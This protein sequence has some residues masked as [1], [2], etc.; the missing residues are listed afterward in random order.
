MHDMISPAVGRLLLA[1]AVGLCAGCGSHPPARF[2][3]Q[4]DWIGRGEW[5]KADTHIHT[6]FSDGSAS[7]Q[8]VV[9]RAVAEGCDVVAIT[10][11]A[12]RELQ[13]ATPEYL[14]AIEAARRKHPETIILAGLEWNIPPWGGEEHATILFPP[15]ADGLEVLS[16]FKE[17][18]DDLG[19]SEHGS[20]RARTALRW[21]EQQVGH[22]E[23]RPIVIYNH[24]SR[25]TDDSGKVAER[26]A[27]WRGVSDLVVGFSGAPGHQRADPLG[28][29]ESG[30]QLV[31]RWDPAAA[32]VG[33]SWDR[34]LADGHDV[35][36]A[37]APSDFHNENLDYW[38]GEF[39]ETWLYVPER[40]AAG[41]FK[42]FRAGSFF[43]AHGHLVR[44]LDFLVH[45]SG[46]PRAAH[47]GE[48]IKVPAG[49]AVDVRIDCHLPLLNWEGG[50]VRIDSIELIAVRNSGA[51]IVAESA[52]YEYGPFFYATVPVP[53]NGL[54]LRARGRRAIPDG[55]DLMFYTNPVRVE[56][57]GGW[58]SPAWVEGLFPSSPLGWA[59]GSLV[60]LVLIASGVIWRS[61]RTI[62]LRRPAFVPP[63]VT[64]TKAPPTSARLRPAAPRRFHYAV[65]AALGLVFAAY[66]SWL[67]LEFRPLSFE[68]ARQRF[69]EILVHQD[70]GFGRVDFSTNLLLF[71]PISFCA[72]AAVL[73]DR[74]NRLKSAL[75]VPA[76]VLLC[77]SFSL[78]IEFVQVWVPGRVASRF[79]VLAQFLGTFTGLVLWLASGAAITGRLRASAADLRS[80]DAV[81]KV[82]KWY[83][84]GLCVYSVLPLDLTIH[85]A[86]LVDKFRE[87]QI[88]LIPFAG[89]VFSPTD[90]WDLLW[91]ALIFVPVGALFGRR[92]LGADRPVRV[93]LAST[94][95]GGYVAMALEVAQL[96]VM[97]R[98]TETADVIIAALGALLG[99]WM[100]SGWSGPVSR[101]AG[102]DTTADHRLSA[103]GWFTAAGLSMLLLA[104]YFWWPLQGLEDG[105]QIRRRLEGFFRLP[106]ESLQRGGRFHAV[107]QIVQKILLFGLLGALL[108][109]A[110]LAAAAGRRS[111]RR[112]LL[113]VAF[114]G[115]CGF[116]VGLEVFQAVF[117]PHVPD[118]TDAALYSL[119]ALLGLWGASLVRR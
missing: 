62:S 41:V 105:D 68:Q 55:P 3:R 73:A 43:A 30:E 87:G 7:V 89:R 94:L 21:L 22:G 5:L 115:A 60:L 48:T 93:V 88:V 67:P 39:S 18:F 65:A 99:A 80:G 98:F 44:H 82:L 86:D 50:P 118:L 8:E 49:S 116:G 77:G 34:L 75:A 106:F 57:A 110:A 15:G 117:P 52:Q 29:Y 111:T 53:A 90:L 92:L 36:A 6:K 74:S 101:A 108:G 51:E 54:V 47:P 112:W 76:I 2:V 28:S 61:R 17:R 58:F 72:A 59:T 33:G 23:L 70:G 83:L 11:H 107:S 103:L 114:V 71:V 104:L 31:D 85:P 10:D 1:A 37:R 63:P 56:P 45:A 97:S 64:R 14:A 38:P 46:L 35:W 4:I 69:Q 42:A 109:R 81:D 113:A 102:H 12:D 19:R 78:G 26:M 91:E 66:G 84:A 32:R 119:G 95:L 13:A 25:K 20:E 96:F 24:P 40:S 16:T 79:D 9:D 100:M 27:R